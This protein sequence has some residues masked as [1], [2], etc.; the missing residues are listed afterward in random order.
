MEFNWLDAVT[1]LVSIVTF[2]IELVSDG[3]VA[4]YFYDDPAAKHWFMA[5]VVLLGRCWG[6]VI[7]A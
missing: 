5:S 1:C 2:Y 6:G 3:L 4:F 7:G